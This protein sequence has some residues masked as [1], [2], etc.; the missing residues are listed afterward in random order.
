MNTMD[1][2]PPQARAAA[3]ARSVV[4]KQLKWHGRLAA[5]T[6][7]KLISGVALSLRMRYEPAEEADT[8]ILQRP[9]I[10]SI[11]HDRLALAL[12]SYRLMVQGR[13]PNRRM[14]ALVS[15]SKDGALV[16]RIL[17]HFSAVPIR[18]STSRRGPQALRELVGQARQG[19]DLAIT[20]DG[21]R[22][23]RHRVQHGV[24]A[25]AQ[26][27]GY[28]ILPANFDLQWKLHLKSWDRFQIPLPFSAWNVRV[29]KPIWVPP[30]A[31]E[32]QRESLR[33]ELERR[34]NQLVPSDQAN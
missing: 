7:H 12:P 19:H 6:V 34:M 21:P 29:A 23:P 22:G 25:L 26:L 13:Q 27:T 24:I 5:W 32:A 9:V 33:E 3:P 28:P 17:E 18:G 20:P 8:L 31:D 2:L 10:F 11:W 14:A 1:S 30:D 15:A 4:P 16:A